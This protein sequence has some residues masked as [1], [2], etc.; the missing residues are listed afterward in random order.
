MRRPTVHTS[1][2]R[3]LLGNLGFCSRHH[4]VDARCFGKPSLWK[5]VCVGGYGYT[6]KLEENHQRNVASMSLLFM[7]KVML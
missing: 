6:G 2:S 4:S 7:Y 1:K 3:S 5:R